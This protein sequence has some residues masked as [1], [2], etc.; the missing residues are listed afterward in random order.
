MFFVIIYLV[1]YLTNIK[2]VVNLRHFLV[3]PRFVSSIF[4]YAKEVVAVVLSSRDL[5]L[6]QRIGLDGALAMHVTRPDQG[7]CPL[8][9][10]FVASLFI[11]DVDTV[12]H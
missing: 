7:V 6:A 5:V 1:I 4:H 2:F 3:V 12:D 9:A 11:I 10:C 8:A